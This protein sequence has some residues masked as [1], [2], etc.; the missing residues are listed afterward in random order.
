MS[1][2]TV[3]TMIANDN[4]YSVSVVVLHTKLRVLYK[5]IATLLFLDLC[6][7]KSFKAVPLP[8]TNFL[9]NSFKR[10]AEVL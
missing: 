2:S 3:P 1:D 8:R 4:T 7:A 5:S 10:N 6:L 9:K